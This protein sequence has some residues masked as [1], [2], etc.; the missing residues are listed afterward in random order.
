MF[1]NCEA[2]LN[3][4]AFPQITR[5]SGRNLIIMVCQC[6]KLIYL[7]IAKLTSYFIARSTCW[8]CNAAGRNSDLSILHGM[9][10]VD[11]M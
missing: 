11:G 1:G 10:S 8:F 7:K 6:N 5:I 3:T 4:C 9:D 2:S